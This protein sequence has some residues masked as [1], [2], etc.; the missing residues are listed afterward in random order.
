MNED[1]KPCSNDDYDNVMCAECIDYKAL[2]HKEFMEK[3]KYKG[4]LRSLYSNSADM[5]W[6]KDAEG[7]YV[8]AN[9]KLIFGLLGMPSLESIEGKTDIEI[10]SLRKANVST[11]GAHCVDSDIITIHKGRQLRFLEE[12]LVDNVPLVLDVCKDVYKDVSG[13][14]IGTVGSA[15]DVTDVRQSFMV[16]SDKHKECVGFLHLMDAKTYD[17]KYNES[18]CVKVVKNAE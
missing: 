16:M 3:Q 12:F 2:Y 17:N 15:R 6:V 5:L 9:S 14:V 13:N 18:K 4:I 8:W 10:A 11:A 7:K 1:N